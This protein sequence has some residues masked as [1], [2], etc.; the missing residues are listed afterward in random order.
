MQYSIRPSTL[1][2]AKDIV[3]VQIRGWKHTYKGIIDQSYLDNISPQKRLE[4][5]IQYSQKSTFWGFVAVHDEKI[6]GMCD[7]GY[8]RHS[9]FSKGEVFAMYVDQEHQRKGVGKLLWEAAA[10]KLQEENL[11]PYI[12]IALEKN[13]AARN[14]Y[15][16]LD[17]RICG[18]IKTEIDGKLYDEVV[19]R[20]STIVS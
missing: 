9:Q 10:H 4:G 6:I 5:R 15:E 13:L 12:V 2:D 17:G 14:F 16:K 20:F 8:S 1:D 19:H 11:I 7:V 18:N 3:G